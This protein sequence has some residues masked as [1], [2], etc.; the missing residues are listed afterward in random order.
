MG[1]ATELV[2]GL[3]YTVLLYVLPTYTNDGKGSA[4]IA[5]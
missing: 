3:F 5:Y 4:L 1:T 2:M